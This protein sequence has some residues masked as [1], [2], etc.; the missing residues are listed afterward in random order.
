MGGMVIRV[1]KSRIHDMERGI[2]L[3]NGAYIKAT[4]E[5]FA[6]YGKEVKKP[7]KE[8]SEKLYGPIMVIETWVGKVEDVPEVPDD[9]D[10]TEEEVEEV[11]EPIT[12]PKPAP[13]RKAPAN[14]RK[15]KVA[16]KP[17]NK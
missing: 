6:K 10:E 9:P 1:A 11:E 3:P 7:D 16:R 14:A 5:F 15:N 17:K 13:K 4:E 12:S 2:V 8:Y